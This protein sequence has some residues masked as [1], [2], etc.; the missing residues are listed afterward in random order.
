MLAFAF[1]VMASVFSPYRSQADQPS[2][3]S[4]ANSGAVSISDPSS[5]A[6]AH[7][8]LRSLGTIETTVYLVQIFCTEGGPRYSIYERAS[9]RE[10]GI[11][12]SAEQ[13]EAAYP[14][15]SL[16]T[17]DFSAPV[18]QSEFEPLM[19]AEPVAPDMLP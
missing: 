19:I 2:P 14:E 11:L 5:S 12:L 13:V 7:D 3:Y 18:D 17:T 16:P 9:R 4:I 15:I 10:L 8:G 6:S 1:V